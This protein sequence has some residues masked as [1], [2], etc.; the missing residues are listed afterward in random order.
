MGRIK[1]VMDGNGQ[2]NRTETGSQMPSGAGDDLYNEDR[3]F[4]WP[5][6]AVFYG[7]VALNPPE[8]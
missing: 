7:A 6:P 3:E 1:N 4:Q 5:A 2:L 8:N